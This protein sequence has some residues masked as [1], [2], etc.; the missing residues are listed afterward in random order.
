[1]AALED[2][3]RSQDSFFQT[4]GGDASPSGSPG[5]RG[6]LYRSIHP[7]TYD[8]R[9]DITKRLNDAT[10]GVKVKH[11]HATFGALAALGCGGGGDEA[12]DAR[13]TRPG[14]AW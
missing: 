4:A 12:A 14:A 3:F 13:S 5:R 6:D 2:T 9:A 8:P 11:G 1:M 7:G 10:L